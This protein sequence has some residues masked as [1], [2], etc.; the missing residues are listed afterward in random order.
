MKLPIAYYGDPILRKKC[1]PVGNIDDEIRQLVQDME[2]T[3]VAHDGCGIS[4]TASEA[5]SGLIPHQR[6]P[7]K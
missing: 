7:S 3:L 1:T 2:E 6:R 5:R 4:R